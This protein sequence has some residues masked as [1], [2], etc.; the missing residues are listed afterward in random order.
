[1]NYKTHIT[2]LVVV[3]PLTTRGK[4]SS[5][6]L[7]SL[8]TTYQDNGL[9]AGKLGKPLTRVL[10]LMGYNPIDVTCSNCDGIVRIVTVGSGVDER[11]TIDCPC[12]GRP[13][14][15]YP[16]GSIYDIE[17][18]V[19]RGVPPSNST[20]TGSNHPSPELGNRLLAAASEGTI[21]EIKRL[22]DAGANPNSR[23]VLHGG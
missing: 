2:F 7:Q 10:A 3:S 21:S 18:I 13:L 23:D 8:F 16:S 17:R 12:C 20:T 22:L 4:R 19:K 5:E 1:M 11:K 9:E 15:S 14:V 6:R